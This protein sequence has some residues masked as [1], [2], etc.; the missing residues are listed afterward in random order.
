MVLLGD[1]GL[2]TQQPDLPESGRG[3]LHRGLVAHSW[4]RTGRSQAVH[5]VPHYLCTKMRLE[6]SNFLKQTGST[7][8]IIYF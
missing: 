3:A 8:G 2:G 7:N 6:M 1:D 4:G 5:H